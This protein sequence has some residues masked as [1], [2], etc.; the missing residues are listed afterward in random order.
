V[1]L[2]S[3]VQRLLEIDE[4]LNSHGADLAS[5]T[6]PSAIRDGAMV[7]LAAKRFR[8]AATVLD[9]LKA[10]GKT[11]AV[12]DVIVTEQFRQAVRAVCSALPSCVPEFGG[13]LDSLDGHWQK[14][15]VNGSQSRNVS[16]SLLNAR[17]SELLSAL[18]RIQ[19]WTTLNR[20]LQKCASLGLMPLLGAL[21]LVSAQV[22][23]EA[24]ERRFYTIWASTAIARSDVLSTF[25]AGE[26]QELVI[27]FKLLD[28]GLRKA[29]STRIQAVAAESA[30]RVQQAQT[31]IGAGSEVSVLR[32]ELQKRKKIKPLR[33]LFAEIPHALQALKPCMLMSPISVST[34]LKPG[35]VI[36]DL[37]VF[38]EASQ[39]PTPEAV[40]S[41]LRAKQVVVAGD[42]NQLPPTSFFRAA[43]EIEDND[44]EQTDQTPE[45]PLESLLDD[46]VAV[47]PFFRETSLK[48]HYRSRDERLIKFS[49]SLFYDNQLI[50]FPSA[51]TSG[52][53]RG[54]HIAYIPDGVWD[55]GRS[56][57]NRREARHT[58]QIVI[59]HFAEYPSRSLGVVAMNA[60]QREA[61]EDAVA[62]AVQDHPDVIP[63]MD[64]TC[65]DPYFVKSL[66]NVQGDER[67]TMIISVG[68][69]KD[70]AGHLSLNF[71]PINTEG[72]WRRL[73]VLVTRA[74]WQ[75]VLITSMRS[76]ELSGVNPNNRGAVALR[77]F[78]AYAERRCELPQAAAAPTFE[79]TNDFED[80]V[81]AAVRDRGLAV[82]Q[83]VGASKFRIDLAIRD[84]RDPSRY[85]LGIE[86]DGATYHS[87]R[88]ARDRDLLRQQ[89]LEGMGWRIHRM[90]ST[91]WFNDRN[92]AI[93]AILTSLQQAEERP[94]EESIQAIPLPQPPVEQP[95]P[96]E[97]ALT[98]Q[99]SP[100]PSR[101]YLG[102]VSYRKYQEAADR[103]LV[104][105][106]RR[107]AELA[108]TVT[109]IVET[110]GP[111]YEDLLCMRLKEICGVDR[112]GTNIQ[113][114][115]T[116]AIYLAIRD[117]SIE[118]RQRDFLGKPGESITRF[119]LDG[120]GFKRPVQ[121]I[122]RDE[123]ALAVLF[124]VEDQFGMSRSDLPRAVGKL[125]GLDRVPAEV[126]DYISDVVNGLMDRGALLEEGDRVY[127]PT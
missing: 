71:G 23:R 30:R 119:R 42:R 110:E 12:T 122:H 99:L 95:G 46:C 120:D 88:T 73:N 68:Y 70:P 101:R 69:G 107:K 49:N 90:W 53:G 91:E 16:L 44:R 38:D 97:T 104:I 26:R 113:S 18:D 57:V 5:E 124:L 61:I 4:W 125:F 50:T 109:A 20:L 3:T 13:A 33:K 11:A 62:E 48:W 117:H 8:V 40:A 112:A 98:E 54:V 51:C 39:M 22:A 93:E 65:P 59:E 96:D 24:F 31:N 17:I 115:I 14:G 27:K 19:E 10:I 86:C 35:S 114:N 84:R 75:I 87:S 121:W 6:G 102:G 83:Q 67:D 85:V 89:V 45:E 105:Q 15:L 7:T 63:L 2:Y 56:R 47:V 126:A 28:E 81:A 123:I 41:I 29:A 36:F 37:V 74:K 92:R 43:V 100:S 118:R 106:S 60:Q 32:R 21:D 111:I 25:S 94:L 55:R 58:A 108:A 64:P 9:A 76:H 72:G 34:Y 80:G 52:D 116:G 77:D 79:E 127:L 103:D 1:Q 82:D 66:E 78:I